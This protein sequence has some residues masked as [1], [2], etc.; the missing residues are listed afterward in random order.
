MTTATVLPDLN[1]DAP[2]GYDSVVFAC[3]FSVE[4]VTNGA[5]GTH[6]DYRLQVWVDGHD[7]AHVDA[8]CR[9][10]PVFCG[11]DYATCQGV[12]E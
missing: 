2:R 6:Y 4:G 8:E 5:D 12:S 1:G 7:H 3:D 10:A 9:F 11:A